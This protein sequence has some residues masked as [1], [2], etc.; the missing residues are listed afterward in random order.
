MR[1]HCCQYES[2]MLKFFVIVSR[3]TTTHI[4][5]FLFYDSWS[6]AAQIP[7]ISLLPLTVTSLD[8]HLVLHARCNCRTFV[9]IVVW[10]I[11]RQADRNGKTVK[12][13]HNYIKLPSH[14]RTPYCT[15]LRQYS[16]RPKRGGAHD[17]A[18]IPYLQF[19]LPTSAPQN[20]V[21]L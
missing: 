12:H 9:C 5:S 21:G 14:F 19:L 11:A 17:N 20:C 15:N 3:N 1:W 13:F 18:Q 6:I 10:W 4:A 2:T 8:N 16:N 7:K